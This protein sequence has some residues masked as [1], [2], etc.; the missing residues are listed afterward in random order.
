V[1]ARAGL[2]VQA[3]LAY[4]DSLLILDRGGVLVPPLKN[5]LVRRALNYAVDRAAVMKGLYGAYGTANDQA[6]VPG[7]DSY[8]PDLASTYSYDPAQARRLLAQAG[9][10]HGFTLPVSFAPLGGE[11]A[12][13]AQAVD[14]YLEKVGIHPRLIT[15]PSTAAGFAALA[16]LKVAFVPETTFE[17]EE[18]DLVVR[19]EMLPGRSLLNP[20]TQSPEPQLTSLYAA[21]QAASGVARTRVLQALQRYIVEHAYYLNIGVGDAIFARAKSLAPLQISSAQPE[22]VFDDLRPAGQ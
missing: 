10:P 22:P 12:I 20:F 14:S 13:L 18:I 4:F 9:Y 2:N 17:L 8:V 1:A 19:E 6:Q 7:F 21:A 15:Y 5:P 11:Q 16:A 3:A